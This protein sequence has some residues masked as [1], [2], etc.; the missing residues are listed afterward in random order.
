M[1]YSQDGSQLAVVEHYFHNRWDWCFLIPEG[2][3]NHVHK[4]YGFV[5]FFLCDIFI[6]FLA[7]EWNKPRRNCSFLKVPKTFGYDWCYFVL[8]N[9]WKKNCR[10]VICTCNFPGEDV[11]IVDLISCIYRILQ[12]FVASWDNFGICFFSRNLSILSMLLNILPWRCTIF[13]TLLRASFK[14]D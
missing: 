5:I 4:G 3:L 6:R 9:F 1:L 13:P 12:L 14:Y 11:V 8:S 2:I 7:S 10:D